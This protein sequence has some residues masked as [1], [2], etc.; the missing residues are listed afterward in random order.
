MS[1]R[2]R[3][4][5][6]YVTALAQGVGGSPPHAA[7]VDRVR[8]RANRTNGAYQAQEGEAARVDCLKSECYPG[9]P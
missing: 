4:S 8:R 9:G 7:T 1:T 2:G 6:S 5:V 3:R